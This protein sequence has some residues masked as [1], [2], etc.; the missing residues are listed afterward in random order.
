[1]SSIQLPPAPS[2]VR[3]ADDPIRNQIF[4]APMHESMSDLS[5]YTLTSELEE[6]FDEDPRGGG[7]VG[8]R[9]PL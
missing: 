1:M 6:A 4:P 8:R 3:A 5:V 7:G 2:L 9:G